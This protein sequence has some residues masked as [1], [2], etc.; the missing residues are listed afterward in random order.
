MRGSRCA[1]FSN[2]H[3]VHWRDIFLAHGQMGAPVR[4]PRPAAL[5][6]QPVH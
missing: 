6:C 4:T 5:T 2:S 3:A 1:T